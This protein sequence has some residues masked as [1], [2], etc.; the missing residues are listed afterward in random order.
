MEAA[1]PPPPCIACGHPDATPLLQS[2]DYS[3]VRCN[4]CRLGFLWPQPASS[5]QLGLYSEGYFQ[6]DDSVGRGYS[7]YVEQAANHRATFRDRLRLMPS[8]SP[9]DRLLDVGAA[10]GF[11]VEQARAAGWNAEGVEL[12]PWA[13]DFARH[14][15]GV[16]VRQGTLADANYDEASFRA[17]T[18]WEVIEHLP[19]PVAV[20]HEARRVLEP[21][22]L[23]HLSTPDAGSLV[24]RVAG[25]RW[26]GWRKIP[27]HLYYFDL[28]SLTRVLRS[29]GFE[30]TRHRYVA[31]TV[32]WQYALERLGA[33]LGT[34]RIARVPRAI[35]DRSVRI[36]CFYDLMVSARAV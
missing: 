9:G 22:G 21:G 1:A 33:M 11:F 28:P 36:N 13:V 31:L 30:V 18:M 12:S 23:L 26:L 27:E 10:T 35:G 34:D 16:P 25:R 32:T 14:T 17:L 7:G 4:S 3:I 15:V 8:P 24:A 20:L 5:E 19:D 29:S 2:G 6:S